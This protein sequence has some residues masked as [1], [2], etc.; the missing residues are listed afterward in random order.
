MRFTTVNISVLA[1][2]LV[3]AIGIGLSTPDRVA[4]GGVVEDMVG[5]WSGYIQAGGAPPEPIR[6]EITS[7]EGRKFT[8]FAQSPD[9][10]Q[11]IEIEGTVSASG[12]VNYQSKSPDVHLVGK[13]DL[14]SFEGGAAILNGDLTRPSVDGKFIVPC[15]LVMRPFAADG[16]V[17]PAVA[18]R[19]DG[20]I[21]GDDGVMAQISLALG[22][23]RSTSF[24]GDIVIILN[25][26]THE[27][28]LLGTIS[29]GGRIIGIA[30]KS[31]PGHMILDATLDSSN[32]TIT[33]T[34]K[35]ELEHG[36]EY[37]GTF[38]APAYRPTA[39]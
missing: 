39:S 29:S 13:H 33:G 6:T 2:G 4:A 22:S 19:Y 38:T 7:Q 10:V 27:L 36:L 1:A 12:K 9:P 15:V 35:L 5:V 23:A 17:L 20:S 11:P 14:L 30:H 21:S 18:G 34:F 3:L 26:E 28:E 32:A 37:E 31:G 16:S 24:E 25:G 8:G